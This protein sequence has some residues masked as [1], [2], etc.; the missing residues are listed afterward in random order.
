MNSCGNCKEF[1]CLEHFGSAQVYAKKKLVDWK[2]REIT[3]WM[4]EK[5]KD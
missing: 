5:T 1:P 2:K 3:S 4:E